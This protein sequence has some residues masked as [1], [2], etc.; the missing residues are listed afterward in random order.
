MLKVR[1]VGDQAERS[2]EN[3]R[4]AFPDE[5]KLI[6]DAETTEVALLV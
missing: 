5:N 2:S 4:H 6:N 1:R 3:F